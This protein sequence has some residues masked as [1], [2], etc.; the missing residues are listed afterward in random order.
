M[1]MPIKRLETIL[2]TI[3]V[4]CLGLGLALAVATKEPKPF[5]V[6]PEIWLFGEP[7]QIVITDYMTGKDSVGWIVEFAIRG[8]V[9]PPAILHSREE[10]EEFL[11][12]VHTQVKE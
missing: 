5:T 3:A 7:K 8:Q 12:W 10:A 1:T 4:V 9:Q 11:R 2:G 6:P